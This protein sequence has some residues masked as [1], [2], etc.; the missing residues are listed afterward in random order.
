MFP[1]TLNDLHQGS[2]HRDTFESSLINIVVDFGLECC[3]GELTRNR[4][5]F[6]HVISLFP[7]RSDPISV[8]IGSFE[9][10][11]KEETVGLFQ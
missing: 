11:E 6:I 5:R 2:H 4:S 3:A 10:H 7:W 8:V 1:I 9:L